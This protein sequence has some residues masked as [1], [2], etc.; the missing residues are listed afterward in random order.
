MS[1]TQIYFN[2]LN[3]AA[4]HVYFSFFGLYKARPDYI[5]NVCVAIDQFFNALFFGNPLETISSRAG[6]ARNNGE[7][8]GCLLCLFLHIILNHDHCSV[9]ITNQKYQNF[10]ITTWET[11]YN[12][13]EEFFYDL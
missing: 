2:N 6:E 9:A 5:L 8:W 7:E 1:N 11:I 4:W 12:D 10:N 13:R 3:L